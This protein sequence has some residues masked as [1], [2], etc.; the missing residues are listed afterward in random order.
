MGRRTLPSGE[1]C[2][3]L[4]LDSRFRSVPA[5]ASPFGAQPYWLK[6]LALNSLYSK[7]SGCALRVMWPAN[8]TAHDSGPDVA[9]ASMRELMRGGVGLTARA[10]NWCKVVLLASRVRRALAMASHNEVTKAQWLIYLDSD[11]FVNQPSGSRNASITQTL[12]RLNASAAHVALTREDALPAHKFAS[13]IT[14]NT[15]VI[16]V[17]A[18][19]WAL[20]FLEAWAASADDGGPCASFGMRTAEQTC[21]AF[22]LQNAS[23][24]PDVMRRH[25]RILPMLPMNSPWGT[26]VTHVFSA[27]YFLR[28]PPHKGA[29]PLGSDVYSKALKSRGIETAELL[30]KQVKR[31]LSE[32]SAFD[33]QQVDSKVPYSKR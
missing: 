14:V 21:L 1:N 25:L 13:M 22:L 23:L 5:M 29:G 30:D 18:T 32:A 20:R 31:A 12:A 3:L 27:S 8:A 16:F 24:S 17:R 2:E 26:D 15:G 9:K 11:A 10:N 28:G 4:M 7:Y 33:C 6:A 19:E